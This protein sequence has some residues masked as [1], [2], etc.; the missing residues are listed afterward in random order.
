[1]ILLMLK[2]KKKIDNENKLDLN[3]IVSDS[4][5]FYVER[6]NILGNYQTIE[7][8]IRNKLIS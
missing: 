3:F 5:K 6:I 2:L 7:E 8:V 4:K 1:M